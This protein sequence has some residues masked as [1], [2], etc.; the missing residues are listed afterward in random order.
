[1]LGI[2]D[3]AF[4][5]PAD[6]LDLTLSRA[7]ATSAT[8]VWRIGDGV[9]ESLISLA[10]EGG[11]FIFQDRNLSDVTFQNDLLQPGTNYTFTVKNR[12]SAGDSG[13]VS[14]TFQTGRWCFS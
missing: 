7:N 9:E 4:L 8:A 1:M 14:V 6:P 11:S 3:A 13:N 5:V 10:L 2:L 12:N